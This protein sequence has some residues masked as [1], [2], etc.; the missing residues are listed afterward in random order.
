MWFHDRL[1]E[2][3]QPGH[4]ENEAHNRAVGAAVLMMQAGNPIKAINTYNAWAAFAQYEQI[5]LISLN[6]V[7]I[8]MHD[9]VLELDGDDMEILLCR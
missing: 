5:K 8:D 2:L 4:P 9:A 7:V 3:T 6:P 1:A